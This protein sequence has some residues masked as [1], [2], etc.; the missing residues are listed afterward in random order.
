MV[1]SSEM[2]QRERHGEL[3]SKLFHASHGF[4]STREKDKPVVWPS[5]DTLQIFKNKSRFR[6]HGTGIGFNMYVVFSYELILFLEIWLLEVFLLMNKVKQNAFNKFL[7]EIGSLSLEIP[8]VFVE[9]LF[10]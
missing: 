5:L 9:S 7:F 4:V 10:R 8:G 1:Q 6:A 2:L 3:E